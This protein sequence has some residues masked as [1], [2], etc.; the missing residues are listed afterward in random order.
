MKKD[1]ADESIAM[2]KLI[3]HNIKIYLLLP[4]GAVAKINLHPLRAAIFI[5]LTASPI[6]TVCSTCKEIVGS[7]ASMS[8]SCNCR[9]K[10]SNAT[11]VVSIKKLIFLSMETL[12][13]ALAVV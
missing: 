11:G 6:D 4:S 5:T 12:V 2:F 9:S 8:F 10:S 1:C 13:K 7:G 3:C